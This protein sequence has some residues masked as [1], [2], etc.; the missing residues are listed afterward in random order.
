MSKTRFSIV[1]RV[2]IRYRQFKFRKKTSSPYLSGDAF[3]SLCEI[4]I[5]SESDLD[6]VDK[7]RFDNS[8]V[9][10]RS[11]LLPSLIERVK[12]KGV[13][14]NLVCGNSDFDFN[15]VP[16][17]LLKVT[18]RAFLQNSS[19]SDGKHIFTLPIGIENLRYGMNGL[20][21]NLVSSKIGRA[22]V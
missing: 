19:I 5:D 4:V 13:I 18:Q 8:N 22:H 7:R 14:K 20:P 21:R 11:D 10:C 3:R 16:Q 17:G 1:E 2:A 15:N 12:G 6:L 9:F